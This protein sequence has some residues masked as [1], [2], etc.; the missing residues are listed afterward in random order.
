MPRFD[1]WL[2]GISPDAPADEVGREALAHR[3]RAVLHFLEKSLGGADEAEAIHQLRVWTRRAAAALKLFDPALSGAARKQ[4]KKRLRKIRRAAG[5]VRDCDIYLMRIKSGQVDV[6]KRVARSL[7]KQ[8]RRARQQLKDVQRRL[9]NDDRFPEQVERLLER[10]AWPKRHSSRK[11]PPFA[12]F[13]RQQLAPLGDAFFELADA[14]LHNDEA[15]H[16]LRIAG[17]QLRYALE[18]APAAIRPS[19]HRQIYERLNELQDRLGDVRD[20]LA[21]VSNTRDWLND[22][23]KAKARRCLC[24]LLEHEEKRLARLRRGLIRWWSPSRRQQLRQRWH[25]AL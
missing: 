15:L 14:D 6:P 16:A 17:K 8:R 22:A 21:L 7:A 18:L 13:C 25:K 1:K 19:L 24:E 20:Q 2:L 3:L 23:K 12:E 9:R 11:A 5:A 10:V 4:M